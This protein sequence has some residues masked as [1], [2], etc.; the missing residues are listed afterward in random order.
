MRHLGQPNCINLGHMM[1]NVGYG[2]YRREQG[3]TARITS[4]RERDAGMY[5]AFLGGDKEAFNVHADLMRESL[6]WVYELVCFFALPLDLMFDR[7]NV[8]EC[9]PPQVDGQLQWTEVL[10]LR[11]F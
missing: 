10:V 6:D 8:I 4:P 11:L 3:H 5:D 1:Q 7:G 9:M 2:V